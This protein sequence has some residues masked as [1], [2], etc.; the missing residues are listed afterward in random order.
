MCNNADPGWIWEDRNGR[1]I[2]DH[3]IFYRHIRSY[4]NFSTMDDRKEFFDRPRVNF[5]ITQMGSMYIHG[6][7]TL[8]PVL[9]HHLWY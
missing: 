4:G 5:L 2:T 7:P 9:L 6:V 1:S 8:F 3:Q